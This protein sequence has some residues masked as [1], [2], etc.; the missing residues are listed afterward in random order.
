V[1]NSKP[2]TM[3][4]FGEEEEWWG[5]GFSS[6]PLELEVTTPSPP[7][8]PALSISPSQVVPGSPS[9]QTPSSP[10]VDNSSDTMSEIIIPPTT[11]ASSDS[12]QLFEAD[13]QSGRLRAM[14]IIL[15]F[16]KQKN[17]SN[18]MNH[19]GHN[20]YNSTTTTT[21]TTSTTT[22]R[23]ATVVAVAARELLKRKR[24]DCL[25]A[26]KQREHR[27]LLKNLEYLAKVE[28]ERLQHRWEQIE[29]AKAYEMQV[30]EQ[31]YSRYQQQNGGGQTI[32]H[33]HAG[34]GTDRRQRMEQS[35]H[36][37]QKRPITATKPNMDSVAIYV[38]HLPPLADETLLRN[39]FSFGDGSITIRKV[40]FYVDKTTGKPKGDALVIYS[41]S[42]QESNNMTP[43]SLVESV[44]SQFN[45]CEL[46]G[47][48]RPLLVQPSDPLYK[49]KRPAKKKPTS[50]TMTMTN[51]GEGKIM[52]ASTENRYS[53]DGTSWSTSDTDNNHFVETNL[54][55]TT[56][57]K[58]S[59]PLSVS[60]ENIEMNMDDDDDDKL[61]DFFASLEE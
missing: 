10:A 13:A 12:L 17:V 55:N 36:Q 6:S 40:H 23:D 34:I 37:R 26:L 20:G 52:T 24:D 35:N 27:A 59:S 29:Q 56:T 61:D 58:A 31:Y 7:D 22:A 53:Q 11:Q 33:S 48:D 19:L 50:T 45:G 32:N 14:E 18:P 28:E 57:T 9:L 42:D 43:E 51:D 21:T 16:Q 47:S 30:N 46:P 2:L 60:K 1:R 44:C 4:D 49:R 8:L 38:A 3:S 41:V 54:S 25:E 15:K 5:L 39:L